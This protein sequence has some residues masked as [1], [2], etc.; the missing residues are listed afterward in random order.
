MKDIDSIDQ[1]V[2]GE[3]ALAVQIVQAAREAPEVLKALKVAAEE[4][5]AAEVLKDTKNH[6]C[7]QISLTCLYLPL[8]FLVN[9]TVLFYLILLLH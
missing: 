7:K 3:V 2:I 1:D 6:V 8:T 4:V 5:V 9:P